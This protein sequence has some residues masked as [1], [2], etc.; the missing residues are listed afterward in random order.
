MSDGQVK[1]YSARLYFLECPAL[2]GNFT[3]KKLGIL[4]HSMQ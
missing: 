4:V 3:S 2:F 1:Q